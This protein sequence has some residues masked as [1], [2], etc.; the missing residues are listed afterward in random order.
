MGGQRDEVRL[1]MWKHNTKIKL[2]YAFAIKYAPT[3]FRKFWFCTLNQVFIRV[4][5]YYDARLMHRIGK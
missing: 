4:S 5:F 1:T 2:V 3:I